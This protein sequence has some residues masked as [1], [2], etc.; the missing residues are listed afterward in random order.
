MYKTITLISC[1]N[2][3]GHFYRLLKLAFFSKYNI[4]VKFQEGYSDQIKNNYSE[5][6]RKNLQEQFP[7]TDEFELFLKTVLPFDFPK[8]LLE[9]YKYLNTLAKKNYLKISPDIIFSA[10]SWFR[11]E[12]FKMWAASSIEKSKYLGIQHGGNYGASRYMMDETYERKITNYYLTWGWVIPGENN[13]IP[14][15]STK[16]IRYK[17]SKLSSDDILFVMTTKPKYFCDLRFM[18]HE[19]ISYY[20]DQEDF[21][22]NISKSL[23]NNF[24]IRPYPSIDQI[25]YIN[26]WKKYNENI[27]IDH[28][29]EKFIHS[30]VNC[31]LY[32]TDH[33]MTTYLESLKMNIPTIIFLNKK[34]PNGLLSK[35][36]LDEF[37]KLEDVGILFYSAKSAALAINKMDGDID[38]WWLT[39][40]VQ[41]VREN[42][43]EKFAKT[44][45]NFI[46]DFDVLF[47]NVL[48]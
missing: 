23:L 2:G 13:L 10:N 41:Q 24:R 37:Q 44:P 3:F 8:S 33:L 48:S 25:R 9:N 46:T 47:D 28:Q 31:K 30:L 21:L 34:Y 11:D 18:P 35:G 42:F 29:S 14:F 12:L 36:S 15:G 26:L 7:E 16:M 22:R 17:E 39:S 1:P 5:K 19:I 32:V 43:C 4:Q 27:R 40:E 20:E 45:N 38:S 6:K